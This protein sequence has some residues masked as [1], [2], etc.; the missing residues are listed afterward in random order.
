M[1][2]YKNPLPYA[3]LRGEYC[4]LKRKCIYL[5]SVAQFSSLFVLR[6]LP[7]PHKSGLLNEKQYL[8]LP[9]SG[10]NSTEHMLPILLR[11]SQ[12]MR[13]LLYMEYVV[14]TALDWSGICSEAF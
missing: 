8:Y 6:Q 7:S 13:N 1:Y 12:E 5:Y 11:L 9:K 14:W 4:I 10:I 3:I 2:V